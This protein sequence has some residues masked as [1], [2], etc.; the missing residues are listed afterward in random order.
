MRP[1]F[2]MRD[3]QEVRIN[4][5]VPK[6]AKGEPDNA[7]S[8]ETEPPLDGQSTQVFVLG[9]HDRSLF[10]EKMRVVASYLSQT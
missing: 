1:K 8:R 4:T 5:G 2:L 6:A 10:E 3:K 9:D 7:L